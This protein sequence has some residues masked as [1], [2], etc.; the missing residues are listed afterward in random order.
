M[1]HG[2]GCTQAL[3]EWTRKSRATIT[4]DG[5]VDEFIGKGLFDKVKGKE[6]I[7]VV[8]FT[9][10]GDIFGVFFSV[11]VTEQGLVEDPTIFVFS[12]ESHGRCETPQMFKMK[13]EWRYEAYLLFGKNKADACVLFCVP[14]I[15]YFNFGDEKFDSSCSFLGYLFEGLDDTTLTG[16]TNHLA[17]DNR[18]YRHTARLIAV[19]LSYMSLFQKRR[20]LCGMKKG[21]RFRETRPDMR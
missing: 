10:R 16:K 9:T 8:G 11:A 12:F 19:Q 1:R 3:K 5:D 20:F 4:Y 18:E 13:D 2:K 15:G 7:A 21:D 6:N 17:F 14:T